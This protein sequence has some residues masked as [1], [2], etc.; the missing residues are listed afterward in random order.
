VVGVESE[1]TWELDDVET[2]LERPEPD[3]LKT[4]RPH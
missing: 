3:V 2:P 4:L 1:L